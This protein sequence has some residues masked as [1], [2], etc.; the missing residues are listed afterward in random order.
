VTVIRSLIAAQFEVPAEDTSYTIGTD[1][2]VYTA[3][4]PAGTRRIALAP[5]SG[6]VRDC[7]RELADAL[8]AVAPGG[9]TFAVTLSLSTGRVRLEC[10][11]GWTPLD[12]H[13]RERGRLLGLLSAPGAPATAHECQRAPW[14]LGAL[15][16]AYGGVW[17]AR[18]SAAREIT[19]AGRVVAHTGSLRYWERELSTDC[20]PWDPAIRAA[21]G[22]PW[23]AVWP[24]LPRWSELAPTGDP[25]IEWSLADLW[26]AAQGSPVAVAENAA[27]ALSGAPFWVGYL[28]EAEPRVERL[29]DRW[30]ALT[31]LRW[32]LVL[33]AAGEVGA[34]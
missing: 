32:G 29:N 34:R 7:L 25:A 19:A 23:T 26:R 15:S 11:H 31:R 2:T 6:V 28:R 1:P 9:V 10:S 18:E 30:Q 4:L 14:Y 16:G 12:L 13:T 8:Q 33:P 17:E 20:A 21:E 22:L 3:T 5:N 24:E 27:N